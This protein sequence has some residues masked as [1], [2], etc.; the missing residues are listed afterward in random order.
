[1]RRLQALAAFNLMVLSLVG[2]RHPVHAQQPAT[3][4]QFL[5]FSDLHFDPFRNCPDAATIARLAQSDPAQ[6]PTI[7]GSYQPRLTIQFHNDSPLSLIVDA[8]ADARRTCPRPA[9]ILCGGDFLAHDWPAKYKALTGRNSDGDPQ[10]RR[11]T[12]RTIEYLAWQVRQEFPQTPFLPVLGNNDSYC[13]DYKIAPGG[14]FSAMFAGTFCPLVCAG[15]S[16]QCCFQETVRRGGYY[17]V[18]LPGR[19]RLISL[20]SVFFSSNYQRC[21]PDVRMPEAAFAEL[22]FLDRELVRA[23]ECGEKAWL[24]MHIPPGIDG[25]ATAH[26][27]DG[28]VVTMWQDTL[29]AD[30][31]RRFLSLVGQH[32]GTLEIGF[33]GHTHMNDYRLLGAIGG[34]PAP[35]SGENEALI[36]KISPAISPLF[37]NN[38]SYQVFSTDPQGMFQFETRY[39]K[40]PA[41]KGVP[42]DSWSTAPDPLGLSPLSA[43]VIARTSRE[44][45]ARPDTVGQAYLRQL[46]VFSDTRLK[47]DATFLDDTACAMRCVRVPGFRECRPAREPTS[48]SPD[49]P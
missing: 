44:I 37:G 23:R 46:Y 21:T 22:E 5:V 43:E 1:M 13:G 33:A 15:P 31:T 17:S 4:L 8:L 24:L 7:V 11:F 20:N 36:L 14:N 10:Y 12:A 39:L 18:P 41:D 3:G 19:R 40:L 6:W 35:Q 28:S 25:Y 29:P 48:S 47:T 16:E 42:P 32:R 9:F 45:V 30:F 34:E 38:P 27:T 2:P 49:R 26:K